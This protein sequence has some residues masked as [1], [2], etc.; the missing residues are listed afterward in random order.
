MYLSNDVP[1]L[2]KIS[3]KKY[4]ILL[5]WLVQT[6]YKL[7]YLYIGLK[8]LKLKIS[9]RGYRKIGDTSVLPVAT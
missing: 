9:Y 3:G 1:K 2:V 4:Y 7:V 5:I 6:K 8:K